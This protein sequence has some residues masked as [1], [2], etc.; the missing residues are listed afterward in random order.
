[1][2]HGRRAIKRN[3]AIKHSQGF[4][5]RIPAVPDTVVFR[6]TIRTRGA[7]IEWG[8]LIYS[9]HRRSEVIAMTRKR[10][11]GISKEKF[12]LKSKLIRRKFRET[13]EIP[14]APTPIG[15]PEKL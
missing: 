7:R 9:T 14:L 5:F 3:A 8:M 6:V 11:R 4:R 12:I 13:R 10:F 2:L 15:L 1:M